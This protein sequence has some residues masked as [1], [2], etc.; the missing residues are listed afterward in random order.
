ML[1]YDYDGCMGMKFRKDTS[2]DNVSYFLVYRQY[3]VSGLNIDTSEYHDS[4]YVYV[5]SHGDYGENYKRALV[6]RWKVAFRDSHS[7]AQKLG[8]RWWNGG[9]E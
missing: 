8:S 7:N 6:R 9:E 5:G 4:R 3:F 2:K 1:G